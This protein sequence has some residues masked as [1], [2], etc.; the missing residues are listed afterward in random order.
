MEKP[1][2]EEFPAEYDGIE[3]RTIINEE[4]L[5]KYSS[6][7]QALQC[8]VE[9]CGNGVFGRPVGPVSKLMGVKVGREAGFNMPQY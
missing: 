2:L 5:D 8:L 6:E 7:F 3:G 9:G 4:L 1:R